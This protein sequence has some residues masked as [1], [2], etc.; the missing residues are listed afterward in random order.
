MI[1]LIGKVVVKSDGSKHIVESQDDTKIYFPGTKGF[2]FSAFLQGFIRA[3]D[4]ELQKAIEDELNNSQKEIKEN[5]NINEKNIPSS[6]SN[7]VENKEIVSDS[8][9]CFDFNGV[10][11]K[12][13]NNINPA[14]LVFD[15]FIFNVN[16]WQDCLKIF[17]YLYYKDVNPTF[18]D[19]LVNNKDA[20]KS[21]KGYLIVDYYKMLSSCVKF[22]NTLYV[23]FFNID[24]IYN[25]DLMFAFIK[26]TKNKKFKIYYLDS[27][28]IADENKINEII[29]EL[30]NQDKR[31]IE[32]NT[33]HFISH[34]N[35]E[36]LSEKEKLI[37]K[38]N[39]EFDKKIFLGDIVLSSEEESLLKDLVRNELKKCVSDNNFFRPENEKVFAVGLVKFAMKY[40][41]SKTFWP[42]FKTEYGIEIGSNYQ[43]K[44]HDAF[45]SIMK[46]YNKFYDEKN[47]IKIDNITLHGFVSDKCAP[48]FF[49]YLF[50]FW[51][52]DLFRNIENINSEF[53]KTSFEKL[54]SNIT[55]NY[56]L[57]DVMSHTA[58]AFKMDSRVCSERTKYI[59]TLI[60]KY[61]YNPDEIVESNNRLIS[62][63]I[64]WLNDKKSAFSK[65]IAGKNKRSFDKKKV[66]LLSSPQLYI[67]FS[68]YSFSIKMPREKILDYSLDNLPYWNIYIDSEFYGKYEPEVLEG[69][70]GIYTDEFE[71]DLPSKDV[72]KEL[73][74]E[75]TDGIKKYKKFKISSDEFR[76]FNGDGKQIDYINGVLQEGLISCISETKNAPNILSKT[77]EINSFGNLYITTYQAKK[78]DIMI[79][80][81]GRVIQIGNKIDEGICGNNEINAVFTKIDNKKVKIYNKLPKILLKI[82]KLKLSGTIIKIIKNSNEI[83]FK[84]LINEKFYELK[85]EESINDVYAYIID[86]NDYVSEDG[87]YQIVI[88]SP[89]RNDLVYDICYLKNL[90]FKFDGAPYIFTTYASISFSQ[91]SNI[92][93]DNDNWILTNNN[94]RLIIDFDKDSLNFSNKVSENFIILNY[95]TKTDKIKLYFEIPAFRWSFVENDWHYKLPNDISIKNI[96]NKI[97]VS[98]PFNFM[99]KITNISIEGDFIYDSESEIYF[100]KISNKDY[101]FAYFSNISSWLSYDYDSRLVNLSIN[102]KKYKFLNII[103]RSTVKS[104]S[105]MGDFKN[106]KLYGF[107]D[108]VGDSD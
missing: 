82:N 53:G 27:K 26:K 39:S 55:K 7:C 22:S 17:Y 3:E 101:Y 51:K 46:K 81:N 105:L 65:E 74:F 93:I 42:Y 76:F 98:G 38:V 104:Y 28:Y 75:L 31:L 15:K 79:L 85:I 14:I 106:K 24:T 34:I 6:L 62:L 25:I 37:I 71:V 45:E 92:E 54:V 68:S 80:P 47:R 23:K 2:V 89:N 18:I 66:L 86:L 103:C 78:F 4:E 41:S 48:Q 64:N 10:I 43:F 40:Y 20:A 63:L 84:K 44:I 96:P 83:S 30:Q 52:V 56:Q 60:D 107:F 100:N 94:K 58:L 88:N 1:N 108:I 102:G 16:N 67:K 21:F 90:D 59:L 50:H 13:Q 99:D 11:N 69:K 29:K 9:Y 95:L 33:K 35:G 57:Q 36:I 72:L 12:S 91:N 5:T 97:Y 77:S 49:D 70:V 8:F 61:F 19:K 32:K 73:V 87:I